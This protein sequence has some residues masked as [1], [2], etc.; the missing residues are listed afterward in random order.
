[1][2]LRQNKELSYQNLHLPDKEILCGGKRSK[3]KDKKKIIFFQLSLL[4]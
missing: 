3:E 4:S 2:L 1:M